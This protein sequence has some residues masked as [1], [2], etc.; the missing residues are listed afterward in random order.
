[1]TDNNAKFE[2]ISTEIAALQAAGN[3]SVTDQKKVGFWNDLKSNAHDILDGNIGWE[4]EPA[5]TN[6]KGKLLEAFADA[7]VAA[8]GGY[9]LPRYAREIARQ[10]VKGAAITVFEQTVATGDYDAG[11]KA[12]KQKQFAV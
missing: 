8:A 7:G 11:R 6:W 9:I 5:P 3:L 10:D 1:M 4:A 12:A 2:E